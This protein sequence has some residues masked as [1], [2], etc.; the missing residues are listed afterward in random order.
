MFYC[1]IIFVETPVRP[2]ATVLSGNPVAV[3]D[4]RSLVLTCTAGSSNPAASITWE[5]NGFTITNNALLIQSEGANKGIMTSQSLTINPTRQMD[6]DTYSCKAQ[7]VAGTSPKN[8]TTLNVTCRF[9]VSY[10]NVYVIVVGVILSSSFS[11]FTLLF[12]NI[13]TY[14]SYVYKTGNPS[15]TMIRAY[16]FHFFSYDNKEFK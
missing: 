6:G 3:V 11:R 16:L 10:L 5:H 15:K 13:I 14:S 1:Y 9:K 12:C 7:N 2:T 8:S 4:G